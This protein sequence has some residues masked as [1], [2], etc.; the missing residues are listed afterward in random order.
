MGDGLLSEEEYINHLQSRENPPTNK[1]ERAL[2]KIEMAGN[3]LNEYE[4]EL[5]EDLVNRALS[6][7]RRK[8]IQILL[9]DKEPKLETIADAVP[10][11]ISLRLG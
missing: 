9:N 7:L 6:R 10:D 2:D 3:Q 11:E 4:N 1:Q 8:Q 5:G